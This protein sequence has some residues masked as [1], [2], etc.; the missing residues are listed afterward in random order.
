MIHSVDSD[1]PNFEKIELSAGVNI[2]LAQRVNNTTNGVGKTLFLECID[3]VLGATYTRSQ[4]SNYDELQGYSVTLEIDFEDK[5]VSVT[6]KIS[7]INSENNFVRIIGEGIIS[8]SDWKNRLLNSYFG[9]VNGPSFFSWRSLL[10]FFF[11][12]DSIKDFSTSLKS[13]SGDPE[14]K[15]SAYQS[16]LLDIAFDKIKEL[17]QTEILKSER[18]GFT[19]YLNSLQ[20]TV[21]LIPEIAPDKIDNYS[22]INI[23]INKKINESKSEITSLQSKIDLLTV[24]EKQ[25]LDSKSE[26]ERSTNIS[27]RFDSLYKSLDIELALFVKKNFEE[28]KEFSNKLLAENYEIILSELRHVQTDL[29]NLISQQNTEKEKVKSMLVTKKYQKDSVSGLDSSTLLLNE[30]LNSSSTTIPSKIDLSINDLTSESPINIEK[31]ITKKEKTIEIYKKMLDD[32]VVH[33]YDADRNVNFEI[34]FTNSLKVDFH[35]EDDSGTGKGNMKTIIYYYFLLILNHSFLS[36]NIDFMILDTD[37]TDG[38]D[39]NNIYRLL[40]YVQGSLLQNNCQLILTMKDDR[41]ISFDTKENKHWIKKILFDDT[42][43]YLFKEKLTK[44]RKKR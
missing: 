1:F 38:I 21:N 42:E 39:S 41:D 5:L 10:H 3:Y 44:R 6:R 30:L 33:V 19:K 20:K 31:I 23:E 4:L 11:K 14:Y 2:I 9:I 13:F 29:L 12:T 28:S 15:T 40:N 27:N 17:S 36:R 34:S 18:S 37:V 7:K 32:T 22:E 25:L 24:Q 26:L 16:F 8:M 43:G 35:Y